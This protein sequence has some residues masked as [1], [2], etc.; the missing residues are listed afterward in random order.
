MDAHE[1]EGQAAVAAMDTRPLR[2]GDRVTG[3]AGGRTFRGVLA[4]VIDGSCVVEIDGAW[5]VCR[6]SEIERDTEGQS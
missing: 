5:I 3:Y 6:P 2:I 4:N 1:P